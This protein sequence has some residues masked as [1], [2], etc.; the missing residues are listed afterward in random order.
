MR[1]S[2]LMRKDE[3]VSVERVGGKK[4]IAQRRMPKC[5]FPQAL[6]APVL[7]FCNFCRLGYADML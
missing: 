1:R 6:L 2:Q 5:L 3:R 7:V 4:G